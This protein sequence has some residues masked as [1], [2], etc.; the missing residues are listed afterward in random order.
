VLYSAFGGE[1]RDAQ[2]IL[3]EKGRGGRQKETTFAAFQSRGYAES[4]SSSTPVIATD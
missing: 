1:N 3:S 4:N 2:Q